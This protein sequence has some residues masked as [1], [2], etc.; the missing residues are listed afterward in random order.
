MEDGSYDLERGVGVAHAVAVGQEELMAVDF[1]GLWLLVQDDTALFF[2]IFVGPDV[3]VAR[4]VVY[5]DS[6]V[7]EFGHFAQK[8]CE[9]FGHYVAVFVPEVEHVAQQ[10]DGS[11]FVLD[12]VEKTY[13]PALLHP[14]MRNGQR[15]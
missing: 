15:A 6:H 8:A 14:L 2:Q 4:K 12:A 7:G 11:C 1:G 3:V 9:T 5:L 10:I 13:Q